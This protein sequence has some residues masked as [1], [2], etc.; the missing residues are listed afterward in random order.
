MP[1]CQFS[2]YPLGTNDLSPAIDKAVEVLKN[3][4]LEYEPG[5]MSTVVYGGTKEL[6]EAFGEIF[7]AVSK[8]PVVMTMTVSNACPLPRK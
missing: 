2:L 5:N 4:G 7:E 1:S 8:H 3:R 6:F